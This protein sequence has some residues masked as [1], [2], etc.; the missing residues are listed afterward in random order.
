ML[1]ESKYSVKLNYGTAQNQRGIN[2]TWKDQSR[3]QL[4]VVIV[5][6]GRRH[7]PTLTIMVLT[8]LHPIVQM[9]WTFC[10]CVLEHVASLACKNAPC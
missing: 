9:H 8:Y 2:T 7:P 10:P 5:V 6:E 4:G 1:N 3:A